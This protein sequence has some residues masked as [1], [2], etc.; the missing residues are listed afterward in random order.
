MAIVNIE[1]VKA[2]FEAGD[3][4]RSSDYIDMIDTLA[5]MPDISGKQDTASA[6]SNAGGSTITASGATVK[7]LVLKG[8]ASQTANLQEWQNSA[9][10]VLASISA[11]GV[12]GLNTGGTGVINL[13]DGQISKGPGNGFTFN[14]DLITTDGKGMYPS[15][16]YI[17]N[18]TSTSTVPLTVKGAASQTANLT[19]WQN[20]A[21]TV[22]ASINSSGVLASN[23]TIQ[24]VGVQSFNGV[25]SYTIMNYDTGG[26]VTFTNGAANKGLIVRGAVSQSANLQ[27]WQNSAG[28]VLAKVTSSGNITAGTYNGATIGAGYPGI[29]LDTAEADSTQVWLRN[30]SATNKSGKFVGIKGRNGYADAVSGDDLVSLIGQQYVS[31]AVADSGKILI[32]NDSSTPSTTSYPTR[33]TFHTTEIG[34]TTLTERMRI[35]NSGN[36]LVNGF[37]ASTVG[38]TVKGAASQTANLQ[39][40][41]NS[42]G[43]VLASVGAYG[44]IFGKFV[45]V[46]QNNPGQPVLDLVAASSQTANIAQFR[47]SA[48]TVLAAVTKDAWLE[49]GSSTAPAANSGV[50]GY[51]YVEAGALKFRGSSGTVTTIANA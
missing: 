1:N 18:T 24:V 46:V 48:G 7:P 9:G 2:K 17:N 44:E 41:Q 11:S 23:G 49:L 10:A 33:I 34:S 12:L 47:N 15:L 31:S 30:L 21:G 50:G 25:G 29:V 22:L 26:A 45:S 8:F 3:S 19:N 37:T 5:A 27:E 42:A 32:S 51:L 40:W 36:V 43:T 28:T 20:S 16:A 39:E 4:P 13:G 35:S 38:L 14:S 6:V